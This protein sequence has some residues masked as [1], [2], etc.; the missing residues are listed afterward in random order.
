MKYEI[1]FRVGV[2]RLICVL[3]NACRISPVMLFDTVLGLP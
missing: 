2:I 1:S 3:T